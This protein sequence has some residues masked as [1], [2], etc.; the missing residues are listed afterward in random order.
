MCSFL[1]AV[2]SLYLKTSF[3][4]KAQQTNNIFY[5]L[6]TSEN[7]F[8][9]FSKMSDRVAGVCKIISHYFK[10]YPNQNVAVLETIAFCRVELK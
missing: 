4:E 10:Y 3:T 8:F 9:F 5:I 1:I 2:H 6:L 7:N